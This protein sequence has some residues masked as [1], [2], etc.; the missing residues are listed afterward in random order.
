MAK[1]QCPYPICPVA[2]KNPS[3]AAK[4]GLELLQDL[5]NRIWGSEKGIL[6]NILGVACLSIGLL[7]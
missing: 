5:S 6:R 1:C 2:R 4:S 7:L 3:E